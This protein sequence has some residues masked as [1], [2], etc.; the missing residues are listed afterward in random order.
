MVLFIA[1]ELTKLKNMSIHNKNLLPQ[2]KVG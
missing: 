1:E 2:L